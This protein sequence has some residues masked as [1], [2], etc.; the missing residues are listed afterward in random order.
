MTEKETLSSVMT[1]V[2]Q[3]PP[4]IAPISGT[5]LGKPTLPDREMLFLVAWLVKATQQE[6]TMLSSATGRG[7]PIQSARIIR[8]SVRRLGSRTRRA[9]A[10]HSLE[11]EAVPITLQAAATLLS[12][13]AQA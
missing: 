9:L 5:R 2:W 7:T 3:I 13:R 8:S 1:P 12:V 11:T 6:T 4:A 10:I